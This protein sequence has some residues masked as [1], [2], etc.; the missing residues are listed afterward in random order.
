MKRPDQRLAPGRACEGL[1][2]EWVAAGGF[3]GVCSVSIRGVGTVR[4]P[5]PL[6]SDA[7]PTPAKPIMI[8]P[9]TR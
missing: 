5:L 7:I 9:T 2:V 4:E 3:G 8:T 6:M 1:A